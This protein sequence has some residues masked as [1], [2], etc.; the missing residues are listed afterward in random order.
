MR[1]NKQ[2]LIYPQVAVSFNEN[3]KWQIQKYQTVRKSTTHIFESTS[4]LF[5]ILE[6]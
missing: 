6:L 1:F 3:K 4:A 5:I 2:F